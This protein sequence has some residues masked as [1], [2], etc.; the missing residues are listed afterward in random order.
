M[1]HHP[2]TWRPFG[3]LLLVLVLC[4][5]RNVN[6]DIA[7]FELDGKIYT[8]ILYA[9]DDSQGSQWLGHPFW[10][11]NFTGSNGQ[12]SEFELGIRARVSDHVTAGAR[13]KSRWGA[14]W[15]DWWE[16]G[17]LKLTETGSP[18]PFPGDTSG[19]SLG[20]NHASYMKLRGFWIEVRDPPIRTVQVIRAGS[21]DLGM[22][23]A[24]TIGKVRY[25]DRDNARGF[26]VWGGFDAVPVKYVA[27]VTAP[28]KEW[29]SIGWNLG[30]GDPALDNPFITQDW[31]YGL[32]LTSRPIDELRVT[33]IGS[34]LID[35]EFNLYDPD[36]PNTL[37]PDGVSDYAV[38]TAP[39]FRMA[40]GTLE[41][42]A[43][44][45][46]VR[47]YGIGAWSWSLINPMYATNGVENFQGFFPVV[48]GETGADGNLLP[49]RGLA[50]IFKADVTDPF[51]VGLS[52]TAEYFNIGQ[53]Y[54]AILGA[55]READVLLTDG[56][57][58]GGQLPTLNIA[59]EFHD[60]DEPWFESCIGWNGVTLVASQFLGMSE[61]KG[62][63][64]Y[65]TYNTNMQGR[66]I[67]HVYPGFLYPDGFTD[68][69][70]Y[71]YANVGDRGRDFRAVYQ[72]NQDRRTQ[73]MALWFNTLIDVGRGIEWNTKAKFIRDRD[74]RDVT[75]ANDDYA[76][77]IYQLDVRTGYQL[78]D[79]LTGFLGD[80]IN[81]WR[82]KDRSPLTASLANGYYEYLTRKNRLYVG[83]EY[84][85]GGV[86]F[87]YLAEWLV[88]DQERG[89]WGELPEFTFGDLIPHP[90]T[91][92]AAYHGWNRI[93]TK[94]TFETSW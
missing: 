2:W 24:W 89:D 19:E 74:L 4:C 21:S 83:F 80:E 85:F 82:E 17:D 3:A 75:L 15:H 28:S 69:D 72:E 11:D 56:F 47:L 38:D 49:V 94:A 27:V 59:N 92:T 12:A 71:D 7:N 60:F 23:N 41:A 44:I 18:V 78:T 39:R 63:F 25:I 65:L 1:K 58:S 57:V 46:F 68:T 22:F 67:D 35:R 30:N 66:D 9:N 91:N 54:N 26:F 53:H 51:G 70:F 48:W 42:N 79:E 14:D 77:D 90:L 43:N 29:G 93:R 84:N 33:A 76:G 31:A 64:T 55:R 36:A 52:L 50:G 5:P 32:K 61:L 6:A 88:K 10:K 20:M 8:K 13:L 81:Y 87:T 34:Y 37:V 45:D 16:N 86:K 62:E 73:I 40:N